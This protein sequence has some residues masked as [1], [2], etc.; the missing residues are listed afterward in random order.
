M[1]TVLEEEVLKRLLHSREAFC[2]RCLSS[3][4]EVISIYKLWWQPKHYEVHLLCQVCSEFLPQWIKRH[5]GG[6]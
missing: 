5:G 6:P 2:E 3:D 4:Q 1:S